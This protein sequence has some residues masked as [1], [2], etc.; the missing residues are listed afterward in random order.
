MIIPYFHSGLGNHLFQFAAGFTLAKRSGRPLGIN[1][2][3]FVKSSHSDVKYAET[4]FRDL[5]WL[6]VPYTPTNMMYQRGEYDYEGMLADV[7]AAAPSEVIGLYGYFQREETFRGFRAEIGAA[8]NFGDVAAAVERAGITAADLERGFF[9]HYRRGDYV[10][11]TFQVELADYYQEVIR[12]IKEARPDAKIFV[13]SDDIEYCKTIPYLSSAD[14]AVQWVEGLDE[15]ASLWLMKKCKLGGAAPNSTFS[16]WGLYL[17]CTRP[18]LFLPQCFK[19]A[20]Y[21]FPE[22]TIVPHAAKWT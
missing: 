14:A 17:D 3:L 9:I 13:L 20:Q 10:G 16:W 22:A 7:R 12:R 6:H 18:Y 5:S 11:T 15:I 19:P 2:S 1:P 8:L 4:I 21:A